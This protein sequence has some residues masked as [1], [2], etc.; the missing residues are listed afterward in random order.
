MG[1]RA[2]LSSRWTVCVALL[3]LLPA[4]IVRAQT[5]QEKKRGD[6]LKD[7][8]LKKK[9]PAP[10]PGAGATAGRRATRGGRRKSER[11]GRRRRKAEGHEQGRCAGGARRA[12]VRARRAPAVRDD[13]Q[14]LPCPG[15]PGRRFT[16]AALGRRRRRSQGHRPL[17]EPARSGGER[18]AG[19]GLRRHDARGRRAVAGG[20]RAVPAGAGVDSGRRPSRCGA[21]GG[22]RAGGGGA[23]RS[24]SA[25]AAPTGG[26]DCT[27]VTTGGAVPAPSPTGEPAA[28]AASR[29]GRGPSPQPSHRSASGRGRATHR[30]RGDGA[31]RADERV[32]DLS[33][34]RRAG[35]D[36]PALAVRRC[37]AR[38]SDRPAVRRRA[39]A[40]AEPARH[41]GHAARCTAAAPCC[42]PAIP[43]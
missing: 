21:E 43:G 37:G 33:P 6:I 10:P 39:G 22:A 42:R 4:G 18:A 23:A 15:R 7:L 11:A 32:R 5:P 8:G 28:A 17:R 29:R 14:A 35:R 40:R 24:G 9:P 41:Q 31:S 3:G 2:H 36:D 12:V 1:T 27:R 16:L 38:R 19:Q 26:D 25:R 34:P 20:R 13:V 30:L